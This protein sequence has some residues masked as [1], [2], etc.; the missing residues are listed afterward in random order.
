MSTFHITDQS[1]ISSPNSPQTYI[2]LAYVTTTLRSNRIHNHLPKS[3]SALHTSRWPL[4][5]RCHSTGRPAT[6]PRPRSL[7][8]R[9]HC[10]NRAQRAPVSSPNAPPIRRPQTTSHRRRSEGSWRTCAVDSRASSAPRRTRLAFVSVIVLMASLCVRLLRIAGA[11]SMIFNRR[12]EMV[13]F[14]CRFVL[15]LLFSPCF[16]GR[17]SCAD[18]PFLCRLCG[19]TLSSKASI[20]RRMS[21]PAIVRLSLSC[22]RDGMLWIIFVITL[23]L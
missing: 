20:W 2:I 19:V 13:A 22:C 4:S 14:M 5:H 23:H 10:P 21:L 9:A 18:K 12:N 3:R 6:R 1:S 17:S 8:T 11:S 15:L 7:P 16:D